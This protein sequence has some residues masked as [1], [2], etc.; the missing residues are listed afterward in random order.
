LSHFGKKHLYLISSDDR[1]LEM[2]RTLE[3]EYFISHD[4]HGKLLKKLH[5]R[6]DMPEIDLVITGY[7]Y[8]S[9]KVNE[10][11]SVEEAL[12][13][14]YFLVLVT[15]EQAALCASEAFRVKCFPV[16]LPVDAPQ[17]RALAASL[18]QNRKK[19]SALGEMEKY[20]ILFHKAPVVQLLVNPCDLIIIDANKAA[21]ELY[22]KDEPPALKGMS[23]VELHPGEAA[24]MREKCKEA[25]KCGESLFH[26]QFFIDGDEMKD[27][28]FFASK[29]ELGKQNFLF[30]NIQDISGTKKAEKILTQKNMELR[31]TN[32]ELDNFVYSTS[33]E[34]RAPLMSVLGLINLLE[35]ETNTVEHVMYVDLMKE[36]IQKLDQI[37]HDIIDYSRNARFDVKLSP[38]DFNFL[39]E[40]TIN[41]LKYIPGFEMIDIRLNVQG[42]ALF[43]SDKRRV[44]IILNNLLSNSLR[45]YNPDAAQSFVD[46]MIQTTAKQVLIRVK[47]NGIGI[48]AKH[49]PRIFEMFFR[50]YEQST[51]S[52]IGLYIVREIVEK[53]NGTIR[54]ESEEG[55]GSAF[56]ITLPNQYQSL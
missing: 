9:K 39:L 51:G 32:A 50:G 1:L 7:D 6:P 28:A 19:V 8:F 25:I 30:L 23:L 31:K 48:P 22:G 21:A 27:L 44:E 20:K 52:G 53:L 46:V 5:G 56:T 18:I 15:P 40:K 35:L 43:L 29:I 26:C 37:I 2:L 11:F 41:N 13:L 16:F 10:A 4:K 45:F 49:L 42:D 14:P 36:S 33:H 12:T 17:L 34:L 3:Q 24:L 54:V 47:D 38:V 55:K